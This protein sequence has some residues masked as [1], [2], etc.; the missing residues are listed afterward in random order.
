MQ[1]QV[2]E[3]LH[4]VLDEIRPKPEQHDKS[5]SSPHP[6]IVGCPVRNGID[7]TA[8]HL[9]SEMLA[10]ERTFMPVISGQLDDKE[11]LAEVVRLKPS[12]LC[13]GMLSDEDT[14]RAAELT[15]K[16]RVLLP[17]LTVV[18][19]CWSTDASTQAQPESALANHLTISLPEARDQLLAFRLEPDDV[20]SEHPVLIPVSVT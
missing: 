14:E 18:A 4:Q 9:L 8:L 17:H 10:P 20:T 12:V 5:E 3:M 16:L 19:G 7:E 13:L 2:L 11:K 15:R 6:L 1:R